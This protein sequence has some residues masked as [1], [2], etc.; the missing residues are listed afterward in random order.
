MHYNRSAV[1]HG[2]TSIDREV[3]HDQFQF[4]GVHLDRP[5]IVG[6]VEIHMYIPAQATIE[7]FTHAPDLAGQIDRLGLELLPPGEGKQLTRQTGAA[8]RGVVHPIHQPLSPCRVRLAV[9]HLQP[10]GDDHQQIVE[11]VCDTPGQLAD[12]FDLL[13]LAERRL[14][15]GAFLHLQWY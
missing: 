1:G 3:E 8:L 13:G 6:E 10:S 7:E 9:E 15:P 4:A 2:V 5:E 12:R 11:V 14:D